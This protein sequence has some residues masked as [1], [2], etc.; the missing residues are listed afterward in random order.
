MNRVNTELKNYEKK[1]EKTI[2]EAYEIGL[3][4]KFLQAFLEVVTGVLL[5][6]VSTNNLTKFILSIAHGELA[7][8]PNDYLSDLIIKSAGQI[9]T[10]SKF[11]IGFYLLTHG[12]IK[13]VIIIGLYLKKKWAYLAAMIGF[14][15]LILYQIYHLILNH[16]IILFALTIMDLIILWLIWHERR[17]NNK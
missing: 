17:V 11:F 1:N 7:E 14:G 15:G 12:V 16:S 13:V 5:Y 10:A 9:T 8:I 3:F 6:A 4:V 2:F